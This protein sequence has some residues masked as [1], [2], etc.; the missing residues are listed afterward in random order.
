MI[1]KLALSL[2]ILSYCFN[3]CK[4]GSAGKDD[5]ED[6]SNLLF[7]H[8]ELEGKDEFDYSNSSHLNWT[9]AGAVFSNG[10]GYN[11]LELLPGDGIIVNKP[12]EEN[13]ANLIARFDHEDISVELD[14]MLSKGAKSD[15]LFM[16]R[17][18][19]RLS[20]SWTNA[21]N[22]KGERHSG[23]IFHRTV[24]DEKETVITPMLEACKA[25]GLWQH[26]KVLFK[27]P[28]F[29]ELGER[30]SEAQFAE[31]YLNNALVQQGIKLDLPSVDAPFSDEKSSG[32][33]IFMSGKGTVA[34]K[35]IKYRA[36]KEE[37]IS[38][39][40]VKLSLL[41]E[42]S[43]DLNTLLKMKPT[44]TIN[45]DSISQLSLN[46]FE[47][48]LFQ[49]EIYVPYS[50]NYLFKCRA[51]GPSW[52]W[53]DSHY[54]LDNDSSTNYSNVGYGHIFLEKGYHSF[55]FA[56]Y[57]RY[58]GM[59][60]EY[61][62]KNIPSTE[63]STRFSAL[64]DVAIEPYVI[65]V[66]NRPILQRTF[67]EHK[68]VKKTHVIAVGLPGRVNF[69]YDLENYNVLGFWRGGFIDVAEM[70]Q[71][72]GLGQT[73]SP[74]GGI[75]E[76]P[77]KSPVS[78]LKRPRT[79]Q[80]PSPASSDNMFLNTGYEI[81]DNGEPIFF[82]TYNGLDVK[83]YIRTSAS[84]KGLVREVSFNTTS[85]PPKNL[86]FLLAEGKSIHKLPNDSYAI[87]NYNYYLI[88][89]NGS[90]P[91]LVNSGDTSRLLIPLQTESGNIKYEFIW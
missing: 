55:A 8:F 68:G 30:V 74:L 60:L 53:I 42:V 16:G 50:G 34:F 5:K 87:D 12:D 86:Y 62:S 75:V 19:L 25:P 85:T 41:D 45:L 7:Q 81:K 18:L 65:E 10:A 78:L 13:S 4:Q 39:T 82:Y 15:I 89:S 69:S 57:R 36:Y 35:N 22:S 88:Y 77:D 31:V 71:H 11:D 56:H 26:L 27:A 54:V 1:R 3:S 66:N 20:D 17:Y 6:I 52:L 63:L 47:N 32:P 14:F 58:E 33:L 80:S 83:D 49:G 70:W 24:A 46:K 29:N 23:A 90:E 64:A 21:K 51:Q 43:S 59:K 38:I 91:L 40:G 67:F 2:F 73:A 61:E 44:K 84:G 72:R 9:I 48:G 76:L 37:R 28:R 79:R